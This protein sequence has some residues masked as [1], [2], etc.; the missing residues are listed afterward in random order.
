MRVYVI[1]FVSTI[2]LATI[3]PVRVLANEFGVN[4]YGLSYHL[5]GNR[6]SYD[7]LNEVN[8]GLGFRATFGDRNTNKVIIEGGRFRDSM[9]FAARYLSVGYLVRIV[10]GFSMG[11]NTALYTSRTIINGGIILAPIPIVSYTVGAVTL[12]GIFLPKYENKNPM[13]TLGF[14]LT[15]RLFSYTPKEKN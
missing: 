2:L 10:P 11:L 1:I 7:F 9:N 12:N 3:V 14:Y 6:E 15:I 4:I 13:N 8:T 5:I